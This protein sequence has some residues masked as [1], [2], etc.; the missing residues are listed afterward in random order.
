M[1]DAKVEQRLNCLVIFFLKQLEQLD[2]VLV[3]CL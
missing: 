2:L 3:L 1:F